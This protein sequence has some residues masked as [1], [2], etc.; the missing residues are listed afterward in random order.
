[1]HSVLKWEFSVTPY[2]GL[3]TC[4]TKELITASASRL[5][6]PLYRPGEAQNTLTCFKYGQANHPLGN[7]V[8]ATLIVI[9]KFMRNS[10]EVSSV[11]ATKSPSGWWPLWYTEHYTNNK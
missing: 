1:M 11:A 9:I 2:K 4:T 5:L 10:F 7:F 3:S 6:I 8:A